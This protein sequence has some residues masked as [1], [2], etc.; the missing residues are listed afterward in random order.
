MSNRTTTNATP[1]TVR[2]HIPSRATVDP[3]ALL[4]YCDTLTGKIRSRETKSAAASAAALVSLLAAAEEQSRHEPTPCT[5][6]PTT[7]TALTVTTKDNRHMSRVYT[8]AQRHPLQALPTIAA[9]DA[10]PI[11][12]DADRAA[13][14]YATSNAAGAVC[15]R[16]R[17]GYDSSTRQTIH[18]LRAQYGR[19]AAWTAAAD[20]SGLADLYRAQADQLRDQ[21]HDL[22][23]ECRHLTSA[24]ERVTISQA[25]RDKLTR[26]AA[27]LMR[28]A[29]KCREDAK[30]LVADALDIDR[31][32]SELTASDREDI[33]HAAAVAVLACD[34]TCTESD[35]FRAACAAAGKVIDA[36]RAARAGGYRS[37]VVRFGDKMVNGVVTHR[38]TA[39]ENAKAYDDWQ[40]AHA[41]A[42]RVPFDVKGG[43]SAG[44]YTAEYRN[45]KTHPDGYYRVSHYVTEA[46]AELAACMDLTKPQRVNNADVVDIIAAAGLVSRQRV[47][48]ALLT[49]AT[50][51]ARPTATDPA[52]LDKYRRAAAAVVKAGQDAERMHDQ[53]TA[54]AVALLDPAKRTRKARERAAQRA[55][56]RAAAMLDR[57]LLLAGVP[58]SQ[59]PNQRKDLRARLDAAITTHRKT[60]TSRAA[61]PAALDVLKM[62]KDAAALMEDSRHPYPG[63]LAT[64]TSTSTTSGRAAKLDVVWST[65]YDPAQAVTTAAPADTMSDTSHAAERAAL[66]LYQACRDHDPSRHPRTAYAAHDAQTA[67][68]VFLNAAT[69]ADLATIGAALM[70]E[71]AAAKAE[72]ERR[73]A[74]AKAKGV[75]SYNSTLED[76]QSWTEEERAA[77]M[78]FINQ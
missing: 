58:A 11:P 78:A 61:A 69:P 71:A 8:A 33:V 38:A 39:A 60:S 10:L 15:L 55:K 54:A 16:A 59:L 63:H 70:Q 18:I 76:W 36:H 9:P 46:A 37:K 4:T 34:Y 5:Y 53:Q 30:R 32:L 75:Y 68:A 73:R 72:Q 25:D 66:A 6:A 42:E 1:C 67:A 23:S 74:A 13:T 17:A 19:D 3:A 50:G 28:T 56:V 27:D 47:A 7:C 41:N 35:V 14:L 43:A 12:T 48:L 65:K 21:A 40:T 45:T 51:A 2:V 24:A 49:I 64:I 44:Y 31:R 57:A 26:A 22:E 77:H 52:R 29:T 62:W 20:M